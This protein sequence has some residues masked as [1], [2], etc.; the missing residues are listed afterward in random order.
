MFAAVA[1]DVAI[2]RVLLAAGAD[3]NRQTGDGD[4]ALLKAVLWGSVEIVTLL[5]RH[6]ADPGHADSDG[7]TA[8]RIARARGY[9]AIAGVLGAWARP[10]GS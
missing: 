1:S 8:E 3:V 5:L 10:E 9:D 7:W 4:T 6:G 2:V